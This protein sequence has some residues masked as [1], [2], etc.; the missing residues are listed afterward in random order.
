V[1][2]VE[3]GFDSF[4]ESEERGEVKRAFSDILSELT[5]LSVPPLTIEKVVF[6]GLW[7]SASEAQT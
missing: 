7:Y 1:D 5:T 2:K 4:W 6:D 3:R